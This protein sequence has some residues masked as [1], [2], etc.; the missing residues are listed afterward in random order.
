MKAEG[1]EN[2]FTLLK[3]CVREASVQHSFAVPQSWL[4]PPDATFDP[5]EGGPL[6]AWW[7]GSGHILV[8][9][10]L[11]GR[12]VGYMI[13]DTGTSAQSTCSLE[14]PLCCW[15]CTALLVVARVLGVCDAAAVT[16]CLQQCASSSVT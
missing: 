14:F 5:P 1:S 7:T 12:E 9:P 4:R 3:S 15:C 2:S 16:E 13:L 10:R 8:A 11:D 6:K